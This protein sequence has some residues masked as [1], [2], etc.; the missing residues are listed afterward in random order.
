MSKFLSLVCLYPV[1]TD[2][3]DLMIGKLQQ[4]YKSCEN[5]NTNR[6]K[7][8]V[9]N[10]SNTYFPISMMLKLII[11]ENCPSERGVIPYNF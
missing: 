10:N 4:T 5:S 6:F 7:L 8:V 9:H 11:I 1:S 3:K 2:T